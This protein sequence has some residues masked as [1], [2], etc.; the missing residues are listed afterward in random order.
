M[1]N[2][3]KQ[4]RGIEAKRLLG[5]L[6]FK[7]ILIVGMLG[8][9]SGGTYFGITSLLG[10]NNQNFDDMKA[11]GMLETPAQKEARIRT[12]MTH[13]IKPILEGIKEDMKEIKTDIR[14][15]RNKE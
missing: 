13:E 14:E 15:I 1:T 5:G 6:D 4:D 10:N 3:R 2:R 7:T 8:G 12:I 9:G 11:A